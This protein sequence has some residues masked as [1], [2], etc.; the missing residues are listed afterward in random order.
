MG[1][2]WTSY[3][4][5]IDGHF[6]SVL[7]NHGI[8]ETI[9]QIAPPNSLKVAISLKNARPDGLPSMEEYERVCALEDDLQRAAEEAGGIL[10]GQVS[11]DHKKHIVIYTPDGE[12]EWSPRLET[13][14]QRHDYTLTFTIR[15]D[16]ERAVYWQELF[17]TED[18]WQVITDL[19]VLEALS[20]S[21]D[22]G[23][24]VRQV[25]HWAYFNS[26]EHAEEYSIWLSS[27]GYEINE[28]GPDDSGYRVQFKHETSVCLG[29]ITSHT[30][31]L[32]RKADE[33]DGRYDGWETFVCK[34]R[35]EK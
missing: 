22:D 10:V 9:D 3:S 21:G 14:G 27:Q 11:F 19:R 1:D 31:S 23:T 18:D 32:R 28:A 20:D 24:A 33:L 29:D 13:I 5:Q 35:A 30:I 16:L 2:E 12:A 6:A 8:S 25:D 17:P 26:K 34:P 4:C 7:Y 15:P